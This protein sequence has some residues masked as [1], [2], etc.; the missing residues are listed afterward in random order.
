MELVGSPVDIETLATTVS[1]RFG[2]NVKRS[3]L[4]GLLDSLDQ[5]LLLDTPATQAK[6]DEY[7]GRKTR[8][9]DGNLLYMRLVSVNAEAVFEW[10]FPKVRWCFTPAFNIF[11]VLMII[12]G[13]VITFQHGGRLGAQFLSLLSVN[14]ILTVWIV[15][16]FVTGMHEFAHGLT[17]R[18]F[19]GKVRELGFMLIYFMPALYCD[20]S[21]AWMFPERRQ[22]VWVTFAGGYF[23]LVVWGMATVVWRVVAE[24]TL[25]S[26]IALSAILFGGVQTLINFNPLIKLDGYYMLSDYLEI[27][28]LRA[29]ALRALQAWVAGE[30]EP[31][32]KGEH[33]RALLFYGGL[34]LTFST[35]LLTV[36]YV[37]IFKLTTSYFAFAGLVGFVM[38][39]GFTLKRTAAEPTA[40][41]M[42]LA[43]RLA[44]K[45]YR[46]LGI[47]IVLL[48]ATFVIGPNWGTVESSFTARCLRLSANTANLARFLNPRR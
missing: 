27:P 44:S 37:N 17:C 10:L 32:L 26:S 40:G 42:A 8:E 47:A 14:G 11:A 19:G 41:A 38:F 36:V 6:L 21:D 25:I 18:Y 9:R 46:N 30:S 31:L 35:L 20:V 43:T 28:N 7:R 2:T 29:K 45:K 13:F 15:V 3:S 24:D 22:R 5:K 48:L 23:Q 12:C 4:E 34:S 39:S 33:R 16:Y 1:E